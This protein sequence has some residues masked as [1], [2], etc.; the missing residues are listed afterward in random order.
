MALVGVV[1]EGGHAANIVL[2]PID[3]LAFIHGLLE[4]S[5]QARLVLHYH[6]LHALQICEDLFT[7]A[8]LFDNFL[9]LTL[10]LVD[11]PFQLG[12]QTLDLLL[13]LSLIS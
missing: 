10:Y 7:L 12:D 9:A 1:L 3:T 8:G 11:A 13:V 4:V 6:S 5:L 2:S